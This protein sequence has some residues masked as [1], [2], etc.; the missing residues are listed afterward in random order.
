MSVRMKKLHTKKN[1]TSTTTKLANRLSV[2]KISSPIRRER[3]FELSEQEVLNVISLIKDCEINRPTNWRQAFSE[4]IKKVGEPALAL[5]GARAKEGITQKEL[6]NI[7]ETSQVYISQLENGHRE[8]N[9]KLAKKL[10]KIFHLNY[11]IF[12]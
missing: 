12:L 5:K 8:I 3:V 2:V 11:K 4:E 7:L 6:A 9:K 1:R 10:A